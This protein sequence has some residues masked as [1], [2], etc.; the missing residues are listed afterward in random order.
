[1]LLPIPAPFKYAKANTYSRLLFVQCD[2]LP[3]LLCSFSQ[4]RTV[5]EQCHARLTHKLEI[6][7]S[8]QDYAE[9]DAYL[10]RTARPVLPVTTLTFKLAADYQTDYYYAFFRDIY[11][12]Q[13]ELLF[14]YLTCSG[15]AKGFFKFSLKYSEIADEFNYL[16]GT[17]TFF[18]KNVVS[19]PVLLPEDF[20]KSFASYTAYDCVSSQLLSDC[21]PEFNCVPPSYCNEEQIITCPPPGTGAP[22]VVPACQFTSLTSVA[23]ANAQAVAYGQTLLVCSPPVYFNEIVTVSC[24]PGQS[25]TPVTI[26]AGTYS[27][28]ISVADANAQALAA[29]TALL[30]CCLNC[31]P[32]TAFPPFGTN[33]IINNS[34][35]IIYL[36]DNSMTTL[37]HTLNPGDVLDTTVVLRYSSSPT[38]F[39]SFTVQSAQCNVTSSSSST[40]VGVLPNSLVV[41]N[42]AESR[43]IN[44]QSC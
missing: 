42:P 4:W 43:I 31:P 28:T 20:I 37:L 15:K 17:I 44:I 27:S 8:E 25:G 30:N 16:S 32:A 12:R 13:K 2:K 19:S 36:W 33:R 14:A 9:T 39:I 10:C 5:F 40:C 24:P 38:T 21:P 18:D 11:K 34:S 22:V 35:C 1:M 41:P 3:T 7:I 26:P 23:D 6:N 29:A